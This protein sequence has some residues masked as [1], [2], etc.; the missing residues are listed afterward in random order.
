MP[1]KTSCDFML[2]DDVFL[3]FTVLLSPPTLPR[4]P[5]PSKLLSFLCDCD[6]LRVGIRQGAQT[7]RAWRSGHLFS[8][9]S[10]YKMDL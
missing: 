2:R 8:M 3:L 1:F 4:P 9:C 10:K 7:G 6:L 5:P